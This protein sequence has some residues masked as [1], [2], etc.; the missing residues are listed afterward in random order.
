[1]SISV[2]LLASLCIWPIYANAAQIAGAN[3]SA[4]EVEEAL[5]DGA[6]QVNNVV[7]SFRL[8]PTSFDK[9]SYLVYLKV[10]SSLAKDRFGAN[11]SSCRDRAGLHEG[12]QGQAAGVQSRRCRG[13]RKG[14]HR[15]REEGVHQLQGLRIRACT[16]LFIDGRV[17]TCLLVFCSTLA[18][19]W[20]RRAWS[21][22]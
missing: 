17:V 6:S 14:C 1:M 8:Q 13:V 2:R 9:K 5:E 3:P 21:R 11:M 20:S 16:V 18:R 12:S 7:H 4:E 10:R 19:R 22:F 15:V